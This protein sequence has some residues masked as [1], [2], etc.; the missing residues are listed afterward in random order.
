MDLGDRIYSWNTDRHVGN[1]AC[2]TVEP[3]V[4]DTTGRGG[5]NSQHVSDCE[6]RV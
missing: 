6:F 3:I 1:E 5:Q 2:Q 4:V